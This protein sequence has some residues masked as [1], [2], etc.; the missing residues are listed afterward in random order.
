MPEVSPRP[1]PSLLPVSAET[2]PAKDALSTAAAEDPCS[3]PP[4]SGPSRHD[5][6]ETQICFATEPFPSPSD[7][8]F[9]RP[10]ALREFSL[11]PT[12]VLSLS[13]PGRFYSFPFIRS[14]HPPSSSTSVDAGL[15]PP[16]LPTHCAVDPPRSL[17]PLLG[18]KPLRTFDTLLRA[19]SRRSVPALGVFYI[20]GSHMWRS[21]AGTG[22]PLL[23]LYS[24]PRFTLHL[25]ADTSSSEISVLQ[26]W[27]FRGVE[28]PPSQHSN[29]LTP[30]RHLSLA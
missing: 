7:L 2:A 10:K 24:Y 30:T 9:D 6:S 26:S 17:Y 22:H 23:R 15:R 5:E 20:A 18:P 27:G 12:E 8:R 14:Q 1:H 16:V 21:S 13:F 19:I 29:P 4:S 3:A 25:P 11:S 28:A